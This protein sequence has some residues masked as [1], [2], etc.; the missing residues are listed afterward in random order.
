[1]T[2]TPILVL[3]DRCGWH[4]PQ[5]VWGGPVAHLCVSRF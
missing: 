3:C 4:Y 1:M 5:S 2:W